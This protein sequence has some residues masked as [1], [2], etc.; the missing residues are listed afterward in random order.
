MD[1]DI[2]EGDDDIV[3][4]EDVVQSTGRGMMERAQDRV[5]DAVI[6]RMLP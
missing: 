1:D 4:S 5:M 6:G 3:E 2:F